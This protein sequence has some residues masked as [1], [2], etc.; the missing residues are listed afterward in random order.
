[1]E[2]IQDS[3][4][5][6]QEK[7]LIGMGAAMG[8]GCRTCADK[9]YEAATSLDIPKGE[10]LK[11]FLLGLEAKAQAVKTMQDKVKAL[12]DGNAGDTKEFS[13]K[14]ATMI[15][16]ASFTAAN[17]APDY[18]AEIRQALS[19]EITDEQVQLCVAT[20]KMVRTHAMGFS[21][22][23]ISDKISG[24]E[25]NVQGAGD[26]GCGSANKQNSTGCCG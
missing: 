23:E 5:S 10:M 20:A 16:M 24:S 6:N 4:L 15:R 26:C 25:P 17:S 22:K 18:L 8:A 3:P 1:M 19:K 13:P 12:M 9:L 21:D 14:L 11:A 7:V 2:K